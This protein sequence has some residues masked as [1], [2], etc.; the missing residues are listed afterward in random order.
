MNDDEIAQLL[1]SE[2]MF[3]LLEEPHDSTTDNSSIPVAERAGA[4]DD[5]DDSDN[6]NHPLATAPASSS[7]PQSQSP[8]PTQQTNATRSHKRKKPTK[9]KRHSVNRH[10]QH[11]TTAATTTDSA[12]SNRRDVTDAHKKEQK[13]TLQCWF[14]RMSHGDVNLCSTPDCEGAF[15]AFCAGRQSN[16]SLKNRRSQASKVASFVCPACTG[17]RPWEAEIM[18]IDGIKVS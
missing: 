14:C 12:T 17:A 16:M 18:V 1:Q 13:S 5:D 7:P 4:V 6:N 10:P 8:S 9:S 11:T 2:M 3:D 15:H